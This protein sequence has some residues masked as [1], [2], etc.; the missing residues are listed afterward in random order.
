MSTFPIGVIVG[1]P[2][3]FRS[4]VRME[5]V[6]TGMTHSIVSRDSF[7]RVLSGYGEIF[8]AHM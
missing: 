5:D 1:E 6:G 3:Y 4:G 8:T 7:G 2:I